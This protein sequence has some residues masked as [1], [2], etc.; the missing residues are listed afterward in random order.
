MLVGA[1]CGVL[2]GTLEGVLPER[3][4]RWLPSSAALGWHSSF[5][6]RSR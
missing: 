6:P 2:L 4:L 3:R 5:R 1:L